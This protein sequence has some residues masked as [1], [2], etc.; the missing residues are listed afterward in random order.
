MRGISDIT[1]WFILAFLLLLD[2][3]VI[4]GFRKLFPGKKR[5]PLLGY[6]LSF[7]VLYILFIVYYKLKD[8]R[9]VSDFRPYFYINALLFTFLLP[10]VIFSLSSLLGLGLKLFRLLKKDNLLFVRIGFILS[11]IC[12]MAISLGMLFGKTDV[13]IHKVEIPIDNLPKSFENF[14]IVQISDFHAGTPSLAPFGNSFHLDKINNYHPDIVVFTGDMINNFAHETPPW[15]EYFKSIRASYG[16][17]SILGNH[18]YG[19]YSKWSSAKEKKANL[20]RLM[21]DEQNMGFSVLRNESVAIK[22][23]KDSIAL[24]GVENW[25]NPPFPRYGNLNKALT[26]TQNIA[27]K[28]LLTHDPNHWNKEVREKTNIQL[29]LSG[30][31]HG[32]QFGVELDGFLFS[33]ASILSKEW[34]GLYKMNNQYLYVNT[35]LGALG[36]PGRIDMPAELT[37]LI[38]KSKSHKN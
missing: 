11:S 20:D 3:T 34:G 35:G 2:L 21:Q 17:Y 9:S 30:H 36:F 5:Y 29:T 22:K 28:I 13:R 24:V 12:F 26:R 7:G 8:P 33:P 16:K 37:V 32:M 1:F 6:S 18:D 38:L 10:K 15:F 23:G 14:C 25:G 4:L 31:T 27:V 19:D